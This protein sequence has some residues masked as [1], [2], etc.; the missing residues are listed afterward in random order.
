MHQLCFEIWPN[1]NRRMITDLLFGA[2]CNLN[3]TDS[4]GC[5][6]LFLA[7]RGDV[8]LEFILYLKA[9]GAKAIPFA[10]PPVNLP[11][12]IEGR[13]ISDGTLV[14]TL[15][16]SFDLVGRHRVDTWKLLLQDPRN[17]EYWMLDIEDFPEEESVFV[18]TRIDPILARSE[19]GPPE[20]KPIEHVVPPNGP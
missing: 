17:E 1:E 2:G 4:E 19:F 20:R 14:D 8:E 11:G 18:A 15:C 5:S 3:A 6:P 7:L 10:E 12:R 9:R 13:A 16:F